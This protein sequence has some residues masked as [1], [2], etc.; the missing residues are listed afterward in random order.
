MFQKRLIK[1]LN[2]PKKRLTPSGDGLIIQSKRKKD[3]IIQEDI[4]RKKCKPL[5]QRERKLYYSAR[6]GKRVEM[7][8]QLYKAKLFIEKEEEIAPFQP[9][10]DNFAKL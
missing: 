6:V 7:M 2:V 9:D 3:T 8:R 10:M 5:Y 1:Q 4:P